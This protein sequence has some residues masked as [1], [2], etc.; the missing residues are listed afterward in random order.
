MWSSILKDSEKVALLQNKATMK[1]DSGLQEPQVRESWSTSGL[2]FHL[3]QKQGLF[4]LLTLWTKTE[5]LVIGCYSDSRQCLRVTPSDDI[6][7]LYFPGTSL[8]MNFPALSQ[9]TF[10]L[11]R[12][13][14]IHRLMSFKTRELGLKMQFNGRVQGLIL[15]GKLEIKGSKSKRKKE[16]R[17]KWTEI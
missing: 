14:H 13:V 11:Q 15:A 4:R 8:F 2:S 3:P 6:L 7:I 5:Y 9:E 12:W 10:F 1:A 16:K 17:K